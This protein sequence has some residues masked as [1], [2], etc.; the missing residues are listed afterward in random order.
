MT[1][2]DKVVVVTGAASGIGRALAH[3]FVKEGARRVVIADIDSAGLAQ[4]AKDTGAEAARPGAGSEYRLS[5]PR[6]KA[7]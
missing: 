7:A 4:V 3:R 6:F 5:C 1:I 2:K